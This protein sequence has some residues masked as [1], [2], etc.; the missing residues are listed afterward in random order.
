MVVVV[1]HCMRSAVIW[2][3]SGL[4]ET[5]IAGWIGMCV[6]NG[7]VRMRVALIGVSAGVNTG[8]ERK[9]RNGRFLWIEQRKDGSFLTR[10]RKSLH[11]VD[12]EGSDGQRKM[13]V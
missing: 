8:R 3:P 13:E 9:G 12:I 4:P 2:F 7:P 6:V 11:L 10:L 5:I 1:I